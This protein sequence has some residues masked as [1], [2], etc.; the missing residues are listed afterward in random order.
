MVKAYLVDEGDDW[1]LFLGCLAGAYRATPNQSTGVTPNMLTMGREIKLPADVIYGHANVSNTTPKTAR[2]AITEMQE[3]MH[4][5]HAI[6]RKHLDSAT[7]RSKE[8]YET[9]LAFHHYDV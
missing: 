6:A 7:K 5:A 1:D 4:K 8:I 2:E 9:R 3:H